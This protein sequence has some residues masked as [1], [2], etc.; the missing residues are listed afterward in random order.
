MVMTDLDPSETKPM[1]FRRTPE[2]RKLD[3]SF[4]WHDIQDVF[5]M[6]S[7]RHE[8]NWLFSIMLIMSENFC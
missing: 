8:V 5:E 4:R 7:S 2:S 1:S 6:S 3:A